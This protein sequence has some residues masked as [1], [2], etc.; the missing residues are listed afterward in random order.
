MTER[1]TVAEAEALADEI[2]LEVGIR[3]WIGWQ[4]C[5]EGSKDE[6]VTTYRELLAK[7]QRRGNVARRNA[8]HLVAKVGYQRA[9]EIT[10]HMLQQ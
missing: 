9:C 5:S 1:R 4:R 6:I 2:N 7:K 10:G 8:R 3:Q